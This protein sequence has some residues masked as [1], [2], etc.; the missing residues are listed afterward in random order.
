[1]KQKKKYKI[2][3]LIYVLQIGREEVGEVPGVFSVG[4]FDEQKNFVICKPYVFWPWE[5][6]DV[7]EIVELAKQRGI[8]I[9][10]NPEVDL[11]KMF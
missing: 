3:N 6:V 9:P 7:P 10:E 4:Y 11:S 8:E 1:M 2:S 5:W